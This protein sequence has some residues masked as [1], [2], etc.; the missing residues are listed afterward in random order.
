MDFQTPKTIA[1]AMPQDVVGKAG[2]NTIFIVYKL[3]DKEETLDCVKDVCANFSALIRSMQNRFPE[4][5]FSAVVGFG[6]QA[7]DK[8]FAELGNPKELVPFEEIKGEK[9]TAVSTPGD[10]FF[11]IR[12]NEMGL[13]YEF[14]SIIDVKLTN[15]V[16]SIDETHG[17]R[18]LDGKAIIGFVDGT[19]NP[20]IDL[21]PYFFGVIGQED[22]PFAGGSYVF[23]QKY[24]HDMKSW[25]ATSIYEQEKV[26]GRHKFND[27]EL[28]DA[29][30]PENAHNAVTNI[31]DEKGNDLKIIRGNMPFSNT[32]KGEYGTYFIGY[33]STFSTTRK[34]LEN[35][36]IGSP[37][38]NTDRL[39]DFSTAVTGTLFFAPSYNLLNQMG[40]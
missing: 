20:S 10:L 32:S 21:D 4:G 22:Q 40:E 17:F 2:R 8:Y 24:I 11:H 1:G 13:C 28:S 39:L 16:E 12:A 37:K 30:K 23:V 38:G 7:W 34:M 33:A 31:Q 9:Y 18:Y 19:E 27:V 26:I 5:G 36:F 15:V 3:L 35:M 25:N 29:E 14:A 6:A